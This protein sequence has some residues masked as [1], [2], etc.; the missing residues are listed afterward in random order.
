MQIHGRNP[1]Q[2]AALAKTTQGL[3]LSEVINIE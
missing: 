1:T 3:H 2:P